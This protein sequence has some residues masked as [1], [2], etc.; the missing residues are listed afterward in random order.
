MP[1]LPVDAPEHV[2]RR[3]VKHIEVLPDWETTGV[4][5]D[6]GTTAI[7]VV[8]HHTAGA[9][10]DRN[11]KVLDRPSLH[12]L[13]Y[14]RTGASPLSPPVV[15]VFL[16]R[17]GVVYF[18]GAGLSNHAGSGSSTVLADLRAGRQIVRTARERG[19]SADT[20]G[21]RFLVGLEVEHNGTDEP[22][23]AEL[24]DVMILTLAGLADAIGRDWRSII[25]HRDWTPRKTDPSLGDDRWKSPLK[26]LWTPGKPSQPAPAPHGPV[27]PF[28]A[29]T[30]GQWKTVTRDSLLGVGDNGEPVRR[31]QVLLNLAGDRL[32]IDGKFGQQTALAVAEWQA[33]HGMTGRNLGTVGLFSARRM[34]LVR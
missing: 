28:T 4:R 12:L 23:R 16:S 3:G 10:H 13:R 32:V 14:G 9:W 18:I 6:M 19:L 15:Q 31:L 33:R 2:A 24:V 34:G 27:V 5:G 30:A 11:G 8:C 29:W 25:G 26:T 20:S 22:W 21:N 7:G 17:A 1:I